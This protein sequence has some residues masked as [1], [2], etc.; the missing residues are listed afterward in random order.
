MDWSIQSPIAYPLQ[1]DNPTHWEVFWH[2]LPYA[3]PGVITFFLGTSL[4][5]ITLISYWKGKKQ[6]ES[7]LYAGL[8]I[9][10]GYLGLLIGLRSCISNK[11][12]WNSIHQYSYWVAIFSSQF[13][14]W[15]YDQLMGYRSKAIRIFSW[16][17]FAIVIYASISVIMGQGFTGEWLEYKFGSYIIASTPLRIWSISAGFGYFFV[18]LPAYLRLQSEQRKNINKIT[19]IGLYSLPILL[20]T[21][22]PSL[23]G[24]N[25][26]PLGSFTFIPLILIFLGFFRMDIYEFKTYILKKG[27]LFYISSFIVSSFFFILCI[28]FV[29]FLRPTV[30]EVVYNPFLIVPLLSAFLTII[31]AAY[32]S[33]S[34]PGKIENI[35]ASGILLTSIALQLAIFFLTLNLDHLIQHRIEQLFYLFFPYFITL[36]VRFSFLQM[37]KSPGKKIYFFDFVSVLISFLSFSPWLFTASY[38]YSFGTISKAGPLMDL[39]VVTGILALGVVLK[40]WIGLEKEKKTTTVNWVLGSFFTYGFLLLFNVPAISGIP[41][42]PLG[43]F[44]FISASMIGYAILKKQMFGDTRESYVLTRRF[45]LFSFFFIFLFVVIYFQGLDRNTLFSERLLHSLVIFTFLYILFFISSFGI[46]RPIVEQM[47]RN[48]EKQ[49]ENQEKILSSIQEYENTSK[50]ISDI[51]HIQS[52]INS[53]LDVSD[54]FHFLSSFLLE[55]SNVST[56]WLFLVDN[57]G[58][59]VKYF[60]NHNKLGVE[61]FEPISWR[62]SERL[63]LFSRIIHRNK[64]VFVSSLRRKERKDK[65]V[66][67]ILK[68]FYNQTTWFFPITLKDDKLG[69]LILTQD[70]SYSTIDLS[71]VKKIITILV[72]SIKRSNL[73]KDVLLSRSQAERLTLRLQTINQIINSINSG[74]NIESVLNEFITYLNQEYGISGFILLDLNETTDKLRLIST[75]VESKNKIEFIEGYVNTLNQKESQIHN[76]LLE[77]KTI[78]YLNDLDLEIQKYEDRNFIEIL[79]INTLIMIPLIIGGRVIGVLDLFRL[80]SEKIQLT[81]TN[82]SD[83]IDI[84][85]QISGALQKTFLIQEALVAKK[86]AEELS[87]SIRMLNESSKKFNQSKDLNEIVDHLQTYINENFGYRYIG[88]FLVNEDRTKAYYT[89]SNLQKIFPEVNYDFLDEIYF[90]LKDPLGAHSTV[91]TLKKSLNLMKINRKHAHNSELIF[92]DF[93][94]VKS[95]VISPLIIQSEVIGFIDLFDPEKH[96]SNRSEIRRIEQFVNQIATSVF[97]ANLIANLN[98]AYEELKESQG[99]LIQSEKMVALGQ[100]VSGVAHEI[101]TPLGAIKATTSNL[102]IAMEQVLEELPILLSKIDDADWIILQSMLKQAESSDKLL[103]T[104]EERQYRKKLTEILKEFNLND[105]NSVAD[106]MIDMGL[107][108]FNPQYES[109]FQKDNAEEIIT[110]AYN[111]SGLKRKVQTIESSVDKASKIVFALKNYAYYDQSEEMHSFSISDGIETVLTIYENA[112]KKGIT[113]T[114]DFQAVEP[115]LCYP[116]EL[117]QVWTNIILNAIQAMEYSGSLIISIKKEPSTERNNSSNFLLDK[118]D[119][120]IRFID[121]GTGIP[122]SILNQIFDPFFTTKDRGEG[123]GLG[124]HICKQIIDKHQGEIEVKTQPGQTEFI[125]RIPFRQEEKKLVY[126]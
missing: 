38:N 60:D 47:I 99:Q 42:Y 18:F 51:N 105:T 97:N 58:E 108:E 82:L 35:M 113:V 17:N 106:S 120:V 116:D 103:S 20:F 93:F 39:F 1:P 66:N 16:V 67:Q 3:M 44:Q 112:I 81:N 92:I 63:N 121:S 89:A 12:I 78:Q 126:S 68:K 55:K 49:I 114:K 29:V 79:K 83:L 85:G 8:F 75:N 61:N 110:T 64:L 45:N 15:V 96:L 43:N 56:I 74:E 87:N 53:T 80:D 9:T 26:Y 19:L 62:L 59:E 76:S 22:I 65:V 91:F 54:I 4:G 98:Q 40:E 109:I 122:D 124:L 73:Y 52:K 86:K 2:Q 5:V 36:N 37:G 94:K 115:I 7:L 10:V 14:Y 21:N 102:E 30:G 27:T 34:N 117:N 46:T 28:I 119:L 104:R 72:G 13:C 33:G 71:L 88:L 6:K 32:I 125:V 24:Y 57:D 123:S 101:N 90:D 77:K 11:E 25:F 118:E 70:T 50:E 95:M 107:I 23:Y 41:I 69:I 31:L 84:T 48:T 100:L 111:L